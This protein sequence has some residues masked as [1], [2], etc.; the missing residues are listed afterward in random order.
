VG[1]GGEEEEEME[2]RRSNMRIILGR[3]SIIKRFL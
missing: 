1:G 3:S 2:E